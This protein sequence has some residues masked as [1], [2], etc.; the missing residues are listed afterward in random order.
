MFSFLIIDPVCF[1]FTWKGFNNFST[2]EINIRFSI[3]QL[4]TMKT[5]GVREINSIIF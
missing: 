3:K 5:V 4:K 1:R 2:I